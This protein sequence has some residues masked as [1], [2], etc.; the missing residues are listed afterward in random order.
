MAAEGEA[1]LGHAGGEGLELL[2]QL[3][4]LLLAHRA[5]QQVRLAERVAR[6][7]L[8]DRHHLLLVDDQAVGLAQHLLERL[9][10]L[11]VQRL[12]RLAAGLA[13]GVLVV[14]VR[15]HRAGTVERADRGDVLE[16]VGLHAAQQG[17]HRA[18]VE[19]EDAE[20]VALL[21]QGVRRRVGQLEVL[22]HHLLAAVVLDVDQRVVEDRQVA[23]PE[24]VHLDQPELL[25]G[26]VVELGDLGAVGGT[27]HHR[28]HVEQRLARHD[29]AGGVHAPLALEP[30]EPDRGVHDGLH[31]GVAVV[32]RAELAAL[33]VALVRR[34]EDL[35]ERDVL[36]HHRGRH[37]LGDPVA[38]GEGVAQDP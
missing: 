7:L 18:A 23:Q 21:E 36:A 35:L 13:A 30:L 29:H 16:G 4:L 11:G 27:A 5:S 10:E 12:D 32:E 6:Q 1:A 14:G 28:D 33:A 9:G 15:P 22:E 31:V 17:A 25:A 37:R 38:H 24:E 2:V 20:G 19:L 34:V 26:R 8:R 3:L